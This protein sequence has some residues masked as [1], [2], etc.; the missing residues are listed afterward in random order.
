MAIT[1]GYT[2]LAALKARLNIEDCKEDGILEAVIDAA[3]RAIDD[4]TGRRFYAV[5]ETRHFTADCR[6]LVFIDDLI[7]LAELK[8]DE[9]GRRDYQRVWGTADYDLEPYSG[10]G[11]KTRIAAN[12]HGR[13]VFPSSPRAVQVAG[14]WGYSASVPPEIREACI[15][16]SI[17]Y[18]KRKDAAFGMAGSEQL[19]IIRVIP[20]DPDVKQIIQS[21]RRIEVF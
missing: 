2:T 21:Y 1:N 20:I 11:P 18:Y 7:S 14:S 9:H 3:S 10:A 6:D 17:R 19:G 4:W 15:I 12:P 8:T 13:F 5:T 16:L